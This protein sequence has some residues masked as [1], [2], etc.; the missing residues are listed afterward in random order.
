[1]IRIHFLINVF[2][3]AVI[4]STNA[5]YCLTADLQSLRLSKKPNFGDISFLKN[6]II[7]SESIIIGLQVN[8]NDGWKSY[9][10]HS[11]DTG[12]PTRI[13]F[14]NIDASKNPTIL[15]PSP[16]IENSEFGTSLVYKDKNIIPIVIPNEKDSA[17]LKIEANIEMGVCRDICMPVKMSLV[18]DRNK[19]EVSVSSDKLRKALIKIP[20]TNRKLGLNSPSCSVIVKPNESFFELVFNIPD[21]FL[22]TWAL[23]E[24]KKNLIKV[25]KPEKKIDSKEFHLNVRI[26]SLKNQYLIIDKSQFTLHLVARDKSLIFFGCT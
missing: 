6:Y 22:D 2:I 23:L 15:W 26:D 16:I 5:A 24:Y 25:I 14:K 21:T 7:E 12:L 20:S 19:A 4:A 3:C 1:M 11:G 13:D 18:F 17:P 9:W 8:L 10:R